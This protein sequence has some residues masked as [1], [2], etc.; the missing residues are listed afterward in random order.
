MTLHRN[1]TTLEHLQLVMDYFA[2]VPIRVGNPYPKPTSSV[3]DEYVQNRAQKGDTL[4]QDLHKLFEAATKSGL[5]DTELGGDLLLESL[6]ADSSA[7]PVQPGSVYRDSQ[8]EGSIEL[9]R[10]QS[11]SIQEMFKDLNL[12]GPAKAPDFVAH[13]YR[14]TVDRLAAKVG[15]GCFRGGENPSPTCWVCIRCLKFEEFVRRWGC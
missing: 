5:A 7:S 9:L 3:L 14:Q 4:L 2:V 12:D 8:L 10:G 15:V 1:A 11:S 6:L 13:A